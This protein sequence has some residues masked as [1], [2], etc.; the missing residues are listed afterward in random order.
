ME[1]KDLINKPTNEVFEEY[2]TSRNIAVGYLILSMAAIICLVIF[3][4]NTYHE[5]QLLKGK[6]HNDSIAFKRQQDNLLMPR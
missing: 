4:A 2:E 3:S 1:N 5:A 6:A